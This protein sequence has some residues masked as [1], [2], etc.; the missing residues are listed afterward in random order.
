MDV[1]APET[2]V[3]RPGTAAV[4][5]ALAGSDR[6]F[7][8]RHLARVAGVSH[9]RAHQVVRRLAE[10]GLVLIEEQGGSSLC[11]LNREH[12]AA[13]A[14]IE[15][16]RLR[17]AMLGQ[18]REQISA[19][20]VP[21]QHASLFGSAARGDGDI[22]SDLDV[23]VIPAVAQSDDSE[24]A[25]QLHE[26]GQRVHRATG[27]H[28]AWFDLSRDEFLEAV[29]TGEPIVEEWLRDSLT[30]AGVDLRTVIQETS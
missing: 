15:L 25:G 1:S 14:V 16:V 2:V 22:A 27:N 13:P 23:L 26:T 29:R 7:T 11:L 17:G 4:L 10:H 20:S 28:V 24:W 30:L 6:A 5:R 19:W 8:I 18:L 21:A 9:S 3:L 12:L